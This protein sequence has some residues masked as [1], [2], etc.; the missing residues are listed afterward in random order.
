MLWIGDRTRQPDG[1]H[2]EFLSGVKNPVGL[3]CGQALDP[4]ELIVLL[5]KL[6]P[7]NEA[8]RIT[9]VGRF[10]HENVEA[11]LP[12]LIRAVERRAQSRLVV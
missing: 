1:A 3:K 4:E 11:H 12:A 8:G 6:N 5:D 9:L 7:E 2:V 10:G